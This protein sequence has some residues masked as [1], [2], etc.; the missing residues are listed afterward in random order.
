MS[1]DSQRWPGFQAKPG[2]FFF[3]FFPG[4]PLALAARPDAS[5]L[6]RPPPARALS[7]PARSSPQNLP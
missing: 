7:S 5:P 1:D 2:W 3:R 4:E 6:R